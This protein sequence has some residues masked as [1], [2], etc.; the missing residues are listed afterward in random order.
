MNWT[1]TLSELIRRTT[2]DLPAD[3]ETALRSAAEAEPAQSQAALLL[4]ALVENIR[5]ARA[6]STPLC[7][8]TGTLT[9]FWQVPRGTDTAALEQAA[10]E[11]VAAATRTGWLRR[12][13]IDTLSGRSI[14]ANVAEGCPVCHF[15]QAETPSVEVWLLQK[16]GGSENMSVQFSLPDAELGAG[17]DIDG[18]R[19]CLLQTVWRAQG[20]G[21]A[22]GVLGVCIGADRA[23]GFLVAKRQL[24]RPLTDCAPEPEL[25]ALERRVLAEA[26]QLGIGP[27]GLGGKTTLLGLKIAAR[28]RLP[29]SYFVTVAYLCWAC[30]RRGVRVTGG[31]SE[32]LG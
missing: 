29:A 31:A 25:A 24:L 4:R 17:R 8:D 19:K 32:W 22:P 18:V 11:A 27:M 14:D 28:P 23:E 7:Q 3:A 10:R 16:G 12:N 26:N 1:D 15:E 13:T 2:S 9:F 6:Q 30:R 20:F 5:L 21:C